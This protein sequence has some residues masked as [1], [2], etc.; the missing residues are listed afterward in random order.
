[1][2]KLNYFFLSLFSLIPCLANAAPFLDAFNLQ[3]EYNN[4]PLTAFDNPRY[5]NGPLIIS[6][7][8]IYA[9]NANINFDPALP[10][11]TCIE[12]N[13]DNVI[14]DLNRKTISQLT[15][16]TQPGTRGISIN[17]NAHNVVV[18]NGAIADMTEYG[19]YIN[20][21][22]DVIN[23]LNLTIDGVGVA[24][25]F[26]DGSQTGTG[27]SNISC[28]NIQVDEVFNSSGNPTYGLITKFCNIVDLNQCIITNLTTTTGNCYAIKIKNCQSVR[29]SSC[30]TT[31]NSSGASRTYGF[32]FLD[33][34]PCL[35]NNCLSANNTSTS[36][37]PSAVCAGFIFENSQN[38]VCNNCAATS[39]NCTFTAVGFT[40][41][42]CITTEIIDC[43]SLS[44]TSSFLDGIGFAIQE[45][46]V[47][48]LLGCISLTN[49][50]LNNAY[51]YLFLNTLA[52]GIDS[53]IAQVNTGSLGAYGIALIA[54]GS[55]L[56][57]QN[58]II[59]HIAPNG[60]GIF[61]DAGSGTTNTILGNY[62]LKNST[63]YSP[64]SP[65]IPVF[66]GPLTT[67]PSPFENISL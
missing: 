30:I 48:G 46:S 15:S 38:L 58:K 14:L 62:A 33:S 34:N 12:I 6:N 3:T 26:F 41:L 63:N 19:I 56:I 43:Q 1:M 59:G 25:I 21:G 29:C 5:V 16:N 57:N 13:T 37:D 31:E 4:Q 22:G 64:G 65:T 40:F 17:N 24:G 2:I 51:G 9:L 55:C 52:S 50:G 49:A 53:C 67:T 10:N 28:S 27:I 44:N 7:P 32:H 45:G 66:I 61:D 23:L 8:G 18:R 35:L 47:N 36:S 20:D 39:N 42:N 54:T 60:F 11:Q